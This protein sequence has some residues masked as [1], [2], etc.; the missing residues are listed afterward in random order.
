VQLSGAIAPIETMPPFFQSLSWFNPLRHYIA[1]VRGILLK[2]VGIEALWENMLM[3]LAFVIVLFA[4]STNRF[5]KQ[6]S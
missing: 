6:L 5:R 2:G 4:I 1:I 3:L